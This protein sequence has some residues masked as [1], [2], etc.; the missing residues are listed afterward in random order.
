MYPVR[1]PCFDLLFW[2]AHLRCLHIT[3]KMENFLTS[4]AHI[5]T[6]LSFGLLLHTTRKNIQPYYTRNCSI[7]YIYLQQGGFGKTLATYSAPKRLGCHWFASRVSSR[8]AAMPSCSRFCWTKAGQSWYWRSGDGV[9]PVRLKGAVLR[10]SEHAAITHPG[11]RQRS[12]YS[13]RLQ[14]R[15]RRSITGE[16]LSIW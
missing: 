14:T 8:F 4:L 12:I 6:P 11:Q 1:T 2:K 5:F 7:R 13:M 16:L 10:Y 3:C 9:P 15:S